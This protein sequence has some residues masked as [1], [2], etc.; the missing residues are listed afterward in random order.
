MKYILS[1]LLTFSLLSVKGQG[2]II[3]SYIFGAGAPPPGGKDTAKFFFTA[4]SKT[5]SDW[6]N[7]FG[8]SG[9]TGAV[10][11]GSM[12]SISIS[13]VATANWT[14]ISGSNVNDN[15]GVT[16]GTFFTDCSGTENAVMRGYVFNNAA[17][18]HT[19]VQIKISGLTPGSTYK[20][21]ATG[22][23]SVASRNL[24]MRAEGSSLSSEFT[25][26]TTANTANGITITGVAPNGSNEIDLF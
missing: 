5:C 19:K 25:V 10:K 21:L 18:D 13:T 4:T 11:T 7:I 3:N 15:A 6:V 17:Y 23:T 22:S 14:N 12:N 26:T 24:V 16:N 1:I 20:I 2:Y 9:P 8:T